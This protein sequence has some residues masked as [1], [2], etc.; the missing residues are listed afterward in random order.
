MRRIRRP[1]HAPAFLQSETVRVARAQLLE[2]LRRPTGERAQRRAPLNEDIFYDPRLT[3]TLGEIFAHKCAYCETPIS[4]FGARHF[5]PLRF[6]RPGPIA[7]GDDTYTWLAYEWH[8]LLVVCD[9]CEKAKENYFP[10]WGARSNYLA[11]LDDVREQEYAVLLDPSFDNPRSHLQFLADGSCIH[12]TERGAATIAALDLNREQLIAGRAAVIQNW[13]QYFNSE[14]VL[15]N[16]N[17]LADVFALN[18][19][20]VAASLDVL[21]RLLVAWR[22]AAPTRDVAERVAFLRN[23]EREIASATSEQRASLARAAHDL[24]AN[25]ISRGPELRE[26]TAHAVVPEELTPHA[27]ELLPRPPAYDREISKITI[28]NLKAIDIL[29]LQLPSGRSRSAGVPCLIILGE[30]S[31]GKSTLLSAIALALIGVRQV[32]RLRLGASRLLASEGPDRS[33]QLDAAPAEVAVE[34]HASKLSASFVLDPETSGIDGHQAPLT[35][36]LGYGPRRFSSPRY[37]HRARGAH[38]RVKSLFDPVSIIP[39]PNDWLASLTGDRFDTVAATLRI[40]LALNDEDQLVSDPEDGMCVIANGRRTP[41][42]WLSEG[43]RSV[44]AMIVDILR[45]MLDHYPRIE[46]AQGIV[47]IDEIETHLHPRWKMQIMTSLRRALPRVQFI[48]TTHDPLCLR[49]MDD[50]EVVVLQRTEG[51]KIR[52]LLDLP[53]IKGMSAEELLTSDYFGLASTTDAKVDLALA[54]ITA[55]VVSTDAAGAPRV[56]L[57]QTTEQLVQTLTLGDSQSEAV[58]Q[59]AL[60]KYLSAREFERGSLRTDVRAEAVEAVLQ[61]LTA[62]KAG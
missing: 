39:Y 46:E 56:E 45:E 42:E 37:R 49:G 15:P 7:N 34:F 22:G 54:R 30:N 6:V 13:L 14:N 61:A 10:V 47:L 40:V 29:E 60:Q 9:Y 5:R 59:Q 19:P 23:A 27:E 12:K 16:F 50:D 35:V 58:V 32:R 48:V 33:D 25:D 26:A 21:R 43:Y 62:P 17:G 52:R 57:S 24:L 8:N 38:Q 1:D 53:N 41:T 36:V 55:D 18:T 3:E 2:Y 11:R 28:R 4:H 31:T 51:N 20:H 44:F